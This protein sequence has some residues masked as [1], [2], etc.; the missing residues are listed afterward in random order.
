[1]RKLIVLPFLLVL[2]WTF[3]G[4]Q[5]DVVQFVFTADVH[6]GIS[7]PGF[8]ECEMSTRKW[9]MRHW[10]RKSAACRRPSFQETEATGLIGWWELLILW[11]SAGTSP[12]VPKSQIA[13]KRSRVRQYPGSNSGR[14]TLM[15][16]KLHARSGSRSPVYAVPG[17][18]D[19]SNAI[20]YYKPM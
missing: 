3:L 10:L 13:A 5:A 12:I 2:A 14:V 15:G 8:G 1:M 19:I 16:L 20:G 7:R 17:N 11:R 4:A 9:S 18:H 6:Y